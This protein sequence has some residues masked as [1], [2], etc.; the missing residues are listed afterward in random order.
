MLFKQ[1]DVYIAYLKNG[2]ETSLDLSGASG[3]FNVEWYDPRNGGALQNGSVTTV[4]G[5]ENPSL[6]D[7][8]DSTTED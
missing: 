3:D 5:G 7:P 4:T 8:P 1:N 2:G 6:G